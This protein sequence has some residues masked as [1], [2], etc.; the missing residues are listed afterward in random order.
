V[1][2]EDVFRDDGYSGAS[3]KRPGLER[4][5]DRAALRALDRVLITAPTGWRATTCTRCC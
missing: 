5:R 2:D 4:L 1:A 3:L